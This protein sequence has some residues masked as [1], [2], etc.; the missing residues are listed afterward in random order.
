MDR[1]AVGLAHRRLAIVDVAGGHQPMANEDETVWIVFNGEIYNHAAL[2]PGLEAARAPLP[3]AQRH[4]DHPP[5]L[6]G[7]GRAL[8]RA[9]ARACSPSPSGTAR[10]GRLLLARDR[11][12]IK[13]LYYA[14]HRRRARSSAPRS[15]RILAAAAAAASSTTQCCPSSWPPASSPARRPSSAGVRKLLP[16]HTLTWSAE[17]GLAAA[18]LLAAAVTPVTTRGATLDAARRAR[19]AS[20]SS[21]AVQQPPHERCAPRALPLRRHRLQRAG[22]RSWRRWSGSPCAPSRS[23]STER[24][25]NELALRAAGRRAVGAEH[26]EVV[27][28]PDEFFA[29][30]PRL[31]WHEDEP[32]AFPS[33]VPLYFVSRLAREHVKVVLTGEGA[34]ELFLGYNRYRVTAWNER[35]GRAV[36]GAGAA[37]RCA[38][39]SARRRRAPAAALRRY[40]AADVPGAPARDRAGSSTRTS[41]S[42]PQRCQR[43]APRADRAAGRRDPYADALALL[44]GGAGG[45]A[46]SH[47]PRRPARP[48]WSSS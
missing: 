41:R 3:H 15:R 33:S 46:R 9:P 23:A 10:R 20:G 45:A 47:E 43:S 4:G 34:D 18:P 32:I 14:R 7:G 8:R 12:G 29:A 25:A 36:P 40:A 48:T 13:P 44:R 17:D 37:R 21:E 2:R 35:L 22:R 39:P 42:S 11:L 16:G 27:V 6:R 24:E 19:C 1:R 28:S 31:V 38:Q 26:R 30:L 5:P